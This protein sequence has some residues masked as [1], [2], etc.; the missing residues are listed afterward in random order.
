MKHF[1]IAYNRTNFPL[2]ESAFKEIVFKLL[3]NLNISAKGAK[4]KIY[5]HDLWYKIIA[6]FDKLDLEVV[7]IQEDELS[8]L[9]TELRF[10]KYCISGCS[11]DA[12]DKAS[13]KLVSWIDVF[14]S[15]LTPKEL[16]S[17]CNTLKV[18]YSVLSE[19]QFNHILQSAASDIQKTTWYLRNWWHEMPQTNIDL[20]LD[21]I[22]LQKLETPG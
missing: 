8:K 19:I 11:C 3:I 16:K 18:E 17:Y 4:L 22:N 15:S 14:N 21:K 6:M 9:I 10:L 5:D 12:Q 7:D 20:L 13:F 2:S 1:G